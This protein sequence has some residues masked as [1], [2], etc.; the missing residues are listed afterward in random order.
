MSQSHRTSNFSK[1]G[2]EFV[3]CKKCVQ[4]I[5][6]HRKCTIQRWSV[7][8]VSR[9]ANGFRSVGWDFG[10]LGGQLCQGCGVFGVS[11]C[12]VAYREKLTK[13]PTQT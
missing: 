5:D 8:F 11:H 9:R 6:S 12:T 2:R 13:G 4:K 10:L 7:T 3:C 1:L